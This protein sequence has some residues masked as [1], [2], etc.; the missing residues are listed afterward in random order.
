MP[1]G[2]SASQADTQKSG[3]RAKGWA[4]ATQKHLGQNQLESLP[5]FL[6][7]HGHIHYARQR[8][9]H[10]GPV[11]SVPQV[12]IFFIH[13]KIYIRIETR[14]IIQRLRCLPCAWS[15]L[16]AI[17]GT[18]YG[19]LSSAR[20]D[21]W[22]QSTAGYGPQNKTSQNLHRDSQFCLRQSHFVDLKRYRFPNFVFNN[23][24]VGGS[25]CLYP[26]SAHQLECIS[27]KGTLHWLQVT[28][29]F[30]ASFSFSNP[31]SRQW[32]IDEVTFHF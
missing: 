17:L 22:A 23:A 8:I 7:T 4:G 25:H 11:E 5:V 28:K 15:A 18:L 31:V 9:S 29:F 13:L 16:V 20:S 3:S 1:K 26:L 27:N 19:P 6:L 32:I 14:D 24:I 12:N 2:R 30:L 21:P 10:L